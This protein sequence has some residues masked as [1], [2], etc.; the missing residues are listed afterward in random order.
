[1]SIPTIT[2][3]PH[4]VA[5]T[6]KADVVHSEI[7]FLVRHLAISKVRG[8]FDAFDVTVVTAANP[9]D[10][11]VTASIQMS[12]VDTKQKDRDNHLRSSDFFL[13]EQFP[14]M[15]FISTSIKID[16]EEFTMDGELTLRG[17][18]KSVTLK[19]VFGGIA[20]GAGRTTAGVTASAQINRKDFGVSWNAVT[21][22]GGV[23]LGDE[24]AINVSLEV[25]LQP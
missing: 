3:H 5:G 7:S 15:D 2:N 12:S 20:S 10:S 25:V 14:T 6:W 13:V 24:I 17:V 11:T 9:E 1:M 16:G 23:T 18:T 8:R 19:G 4:Y 22:A 21:E